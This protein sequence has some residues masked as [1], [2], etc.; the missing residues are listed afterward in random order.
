MR[1]QTS[2]VVL[3]AVTGTV[4]VASLGGAYLVRAAWQA[5]QAPPAL[6]SGEADPEPSGRMRGG[7]RVVDLEALNYAFS[8]ERIV[9]RKGEKVVLRARSVEGVHGLCVPGLGIQRLLRPDELEEVTFTAG[10]AG[11]HPF[12][13]HIP[14]GPGHYRM[15]GRIVVLEEEAVADR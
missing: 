1:E 5:R 11:V 12:H 2:I 10:E 13:C 3:L 7:E 8:P 6:P 15:K 9:V 14:C 4:V